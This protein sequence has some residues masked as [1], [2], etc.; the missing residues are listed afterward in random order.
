[1]NNLNNLNFTN[2]N[3]AA[4][5]PAA[6]NNTPKVAKKYKYIYILTD[7]V[8]AET[9]HSVLIGGS[10]IMKNGFA[11]WFFKSGIFKNDFYQPHIITLSIDVTSEGSTLYKITTTKE[12]ENAQEYQ[13]D[14]IKLFSIYERWINGIVEILHDKDKLTAFIAEQGIKN[15]IVRDLYIARLW[16]VAERWEKANNT[17]KPAAK[18]VPADLE[19]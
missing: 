2:N 4:A 7:D 12:T 13:I 6:N 5:T 3:Q 15:N 9:K 19:I 8:I 14:G 10:N 16:Q 18:Q 11:F 1:M 17:T